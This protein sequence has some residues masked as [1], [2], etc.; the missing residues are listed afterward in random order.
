MVASRTRTRTPRRA[1][2]AGRRATVREL[3]L[4]GADV[5]HD[6]PALLFREVLPGGHGPAPVR[7]LPEDLAVCLLLHL[8]GGPV[9]RLGR[10]RRR[11]RTIAL[12]AG[13]RARPAAL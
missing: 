4:E 9:G 12:V 13:A 1:E 2:P 11:G 6:L 5:V 8:V 10:Q 7:D 3:L